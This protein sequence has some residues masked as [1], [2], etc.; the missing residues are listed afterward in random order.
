MT[1]A[2]LQLQEVSTVQAGPGQGAT[3]LLTSGQTVTLPAHQTRRACLVPT[4]DGGV[5]L[6]DWTAQDGPAYRVPAALCA[7]LSRVFG[8]SRAGV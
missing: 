6:P 2:A 5:F 3:L 7:T 8:L 1:P 4:A